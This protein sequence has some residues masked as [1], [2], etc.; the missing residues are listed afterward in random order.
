MVIMNRFF[1]ACLLVVCTTSSTAFLLAAIG[2]LF[3]QFATIGLAFL[4]AAIAAVASAIIVALWV[5]P[6]HLMFVKYNVAGLGWYITLSLVPGLAFPVLYSIL[7]ETD[8]PGVVFASCLMA[9]ILS[10]VVFWYV[11]VN[12]QPK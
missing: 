3:D 9:A 11:A 7:V 10:A 1:I 5:V 2:S 8:I 4:I 6:I 12:G